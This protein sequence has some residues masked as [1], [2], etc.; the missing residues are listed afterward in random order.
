VQLALSGTVPLQVALIAMLS[1]HFL[2]GIGE[3]L[4][5]LA[6]VNYIWRTRPD[7]IYDSPR[8]LVNS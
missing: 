2:I 7:L 1:W 4:I 5:T 6:A 8:S 3:A